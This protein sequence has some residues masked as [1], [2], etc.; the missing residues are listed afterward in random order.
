MRIVFEDGFGVA[1]RF[2]GYLRENNVWVKCLA[3]GPTMENYW[4]CDEH[5]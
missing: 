4:R 1:E 2:Y 3:Y 5:G